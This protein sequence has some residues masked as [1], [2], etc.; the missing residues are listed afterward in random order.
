MDLAHL[1]LGNP[2]AFH[3]FFRLRLARTRSPISVRVVRMK[4]S[5]V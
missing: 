4:L 1:L 2:D 5:M 3:V